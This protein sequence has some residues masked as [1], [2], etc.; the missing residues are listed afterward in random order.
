MSASTNDAWSS[1]LFKVFDAYVWLWFYVQVCQRWTFLWFW[2]WRIAQNLKLGIL[3]AKGT[4]RRNSQAVTKMAHG[5]VKRTWSEKSYQSI[6]NGSGDFLGLRNQILVLT[7][8]TFVAQP[9]WEWLSWL[10]WR[11]QPY[12]E[13]VCLFANLPSDRIPCGGGYHS[14]DPHNLG[15]ADWFLVHMKKPRAD[16]KITRSQNDNS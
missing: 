15:R 6:K 11:E 16:R 5:L 13:W 12:R 7:F 14:S 8:R 2:S 10:T 3:A 9:Y 4:A 1:K